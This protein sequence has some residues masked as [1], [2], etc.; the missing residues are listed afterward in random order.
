MA[1]TDIAKRAVGDCI[2]KSWLDTFIDNL[3]H[4]YNSAGGSGTGSSGSL[5]N[6]SF[7]N[8]TDADGIPDG[9]TRTLYTGGSFAIETT[10]P[11]HGAKSIKFTSPGGAGN[12]G[13]Y[14]DNDDYI[15][16][17]EVR[18]VVLRWVMWGTADVNNLVDVLFYDKAKGY[19]STT[20]L[21]TNAATNP[22]TAT[23]KHYSATPPADARYFRVR[24][25]GCKNDDTTAGSTYFDDV[26]I[27]TSIGS[28]VGYAETAANEDRPA[29]RIHIATSLSSVVFTAPNNVWVSLSGAKVDV[30]GGGDVVIDLR[31]SAGNSRLTV[32]LAL[33]LGTYT[34]Y[35]SATW[36]TYAAGPLSEHYLT[37]MA[38][39]QEA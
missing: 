1:W 25:T 27:G 33:P 17:S 24:L 30:A 3:V 14:I 36:W 16:C 19:L 38:I 34:I 35:A 23:Q 8:D 4:L 9:W 22:T 20:N 6:G 29:D 31:D 15:L 32:T 10:A 37:A 11:E 21:Y 13:G 18:P 28:V 12:G 39:R 5:Q 2:P 26:A 7:E